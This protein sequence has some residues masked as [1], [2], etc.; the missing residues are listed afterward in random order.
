VVFACVLFAVVGV[1]A[2]AV[3]VYKRRWLL[4]VAAILGSGSAELGLAALTFHRLWINLVAMGAALAAG[5]FGL[6]DAR[7]Q[8]RAANAQQQS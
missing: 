6:T 4:A 1:V 2:T 7:R 8:V 5:G 3:R